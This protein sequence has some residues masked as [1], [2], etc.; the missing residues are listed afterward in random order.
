[1]GKYIFSFRR[2]IV[3][4]ICFVIFFAPMQSRAKVG[5]SFD[6]LSIGP[7]SIGIKVPMSGVLKLLTGTI[8][9]TEVLVSYFSPINKG[10]NTHAYIASY[11]EENGSH[12]SKKT[13]FHFTIE[14]DEYMK[15]KPLRIKYHDI[16]VDDKI[17]LSKGFL[18]IEDDGKMVFNGVDFKGYMHLHYNKKLSVW[19]EQNNLLLVLAIEDGHKILILQEE[20]S[21]VSHVLKAIL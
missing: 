20:S 14:P 8:A 4:I 12:K 2:L 6:I 18:S 3:T 19:D 11:P 13:N 16:I 1:M 21:S 5:I 17:L 9:I 10:S 7:F 15:G